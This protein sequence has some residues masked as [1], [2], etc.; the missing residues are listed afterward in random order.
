MHELR[1]CIQEALDD[2]N[3]DYDEI[4]LLTKITSC[5]RRAQEPSN[6][7]PY[8]SMQRGDTEEYNPDT[9]IDERPPP[10][11][12]IGGKKSRRRHHR[13]KSRRNRSK[14]HKRK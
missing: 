1:D 11:Q 4:V 10:D 5:L 2:Y 8:A 9:D 3:E 6:V 13:H 12:I 14:S 7:D